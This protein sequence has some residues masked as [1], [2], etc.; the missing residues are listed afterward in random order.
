MPKASP[1][2]ANVNQH[3]QLLADFDGF[4]RSGAPA[5]ALMQH[6]SDCMHQQLV[7]YNWVGF[8]LIDK[9]DPDFLVL[10]PY[11]GTNTVHT[12]ISLSSGLC[13]AAATTGQTVVVNDVATDPRYLMGSE[14]TKSEIIVPV[15]AQKAHGFPLQ[16]SRALNG[17]V[18]E[19]DINSYFKDTFDQSER[20][21]VES[22]AALIGRHL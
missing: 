15:M 10:G 5:K 21:F 12:R 9:D 16:S 6:I 14:H 7:R 8:Y 3:K 22:V 1:A 18:G 17:V 2:S 13:G 11:S 20:A 19:L 4:A